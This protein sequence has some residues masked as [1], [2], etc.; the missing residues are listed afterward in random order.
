MPRNHYEQFFT[1]GLGRGA[2]QVQR[3]HALESLRDLIPGYTEEQADLGLAG[4]STSTTGAALGLLSLVPGL[5]WLA[6]PALALGAGGSFIPDIFGD[7]GGGKQEARR[8]SADLS[9]ANATLAATD[10]QAAGVGEG[11]A[12]LSQQTAERDIARAGQDAQETQE[13]ASKV[14]TA[15]DIMGILSMVG[16]ALKPSA[17][18]AKAPVTEVKPGPMWA[19]GATRAP[20][21]LSPAMNLGSLTSSPLATPV[22]QGPWGAA[23]SQMWTASGPALFGGGVE[24]PFGISRRAAQNRNPY[25]QYFGR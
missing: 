15:G 13:I 22:P 17:G 9:E 1:P 3:L 7:S 2:A 14:G 6:A 10:P 16:G 5:G 12:A 23:N 20:W 18:L 19:E 8:A 25:E 4:A 21:D 11:L 24:G